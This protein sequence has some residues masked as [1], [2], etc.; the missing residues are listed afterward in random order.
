MMSISAVEELAKPLTEDEQVEWKIR[1]TQG[2]PSNIREKISESI[3]VSYVEKIEEKILMPEILMKE[4][5]PCERPLQAL[6][7][8]K[9]E[10]AKQIRP[11]EEQ[12][13][14]AEVVKFLVEII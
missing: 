11:V 9:K 13:V 5:Q 3:G 1:E 10:N 12:I 7:Y 14:Q 2:A 4:E 8:M 6:L